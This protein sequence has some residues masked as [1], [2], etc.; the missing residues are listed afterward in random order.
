MLQHIITTGMRTGVVAIVFTDVQASTQL[1]ESC[2]GMKLALKTHNK[3]I[4]DSIDLFGGYEVKTIGDAYM[5][6]FDSAHKACDFSLH[7][8]EMLFESEWTQDVLEHP[9]CRTDEVAKL[10]GLRIRIGINFGDADVEFNPVTGR[11][12]YFGS[13]VNKASRVES[14]GIAGAVTVSKEVLDEVLDAKS[15]TNI[16]TVSVETAG[17]DFSGLSVPCSLYNIGKVDLK[18]VASQSFLAVLVPVKLALRAV[19]VKQEISRRKRG[20][21]SN[22]VP[23]GKE[24]DLDRRSSGASSVSRNSGGRMRK[25]RMNKYELKNEATLARIGVAIETATESQEAMATANDGLGKVLSCLDRS[26]GTVVSVLSCSVQASWNTARPCA[27]H[28]EG[29]FRFLRLLRSSIVDKPEFYRTFSIGVATGS[30]LYGNVGNTMQKF[31]TCVGAAVDLSGHLSSSAALLGVYCLHGA[32]PRQGSTAFSDENL[33]RNCRPVDIWDVKNR[34]GESVVVYE[35]RTDTG[36][37]RWGQEDELTQVTHQANWGWTD[38][39]IDA[40]E[41]KDHFKIAT[42]SKEDEVL[43]TVAEMLKSQTGLRAAV[44]L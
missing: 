13:T 43:Q 27:N 42:Y 30:V 32:V 5:V 44:R 38:E 1:W 17:G 3:V 34:P 11:Y 39:Y 33:K 16:E 31:I 36:S 25:H 26:E 2:P 41:K 22:A 9:L 12:D 28:L 15:L 19:Y 40:F 14:V 4:R 23:V 29:G 24:R 35:V 6:A 21:L 37:D 8:Q 18:G 10:R 20:S 7:V